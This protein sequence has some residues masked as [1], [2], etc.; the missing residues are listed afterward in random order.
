MDEQ[1]EKVSLTDKRIISR[2]LGYAK[3]QKKTFLVALAMMVI[4][5]GFDLLLPIL[6][7]L[8]A[9]IL[10][11]DVIDFNRIIYIVIAYAVCLAVMFVIQYYQGMSLQKAGQKIIYNVRE[12]VFSHIENYSTG[13]INSLPVGKMVTRITNDTNTLNEMYTSVIMNLLKD[14]LTVVGVI[15][16][17]LLVD[18]Q[19]SLYVLAV[20]PVLVFITFIFRK[21]SREAYRQVRK[22]IANINAFLSENISGMK[23]TQVFNQEE[24]KLREFREKNQTL[25]R[26]SLR[27]TFIFGVFRPMIYVLYV[28]TLILILWFGG[29]NVM[30]QI[31]LTFE[32]IIIFYQ[33]LDKLYTP[34]QQLAEQFNVLQSAF[35]AAE[36]IF[37]VLDKTPEIV[38]EEGA[39]P[40]TD[41]K[42][43]I[44][45]KNVWFSYIDG[46]WILKDVSFK[47]LPGETVAF[48]GATG[49]GKTTI[50]SL[51]VR[52]YEIQKGQILIDGLDIKK[53]KIASLRSGIGQMLQDVFLFSGTIASNIRM[54]EESIS[55]SDI[56][57]A[58]EYVNADKFISGLP[59]GYQEEVRER[60]NNFSSGQRQLLSFARTVVH[61]PKIM[62]LDEAT[63]NID[64]E[65]E[66]LIQDSLEKMMNIGTMLVVAHRLSTIQ[67]ANKIIVLQ[68]GTII[69]EGTHQELLKKR[70][71][72][73]KLY[74]LQYQSEK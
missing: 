54:R 40:L 38:D 13:Q 18:V 50:L 24:K 43:E 41:L 8:A 52:N 65:T 67:H 69:E 15:I 63:A 35:A 59:N 32:V 34:I 57:Q 42:G 4:S 39:V 23:I 44:E 16:A 21:Y 31:G 62:I 30:L 73:Y 72:Y 7:G 6:L 11:Q 26:S 12:Q 56:Q 47:I 55:D 10:G 46:E 48:V 58:C 28:L 36:K 53:I 25:K 17:M 66:V 61:K 68:K 60:G 33:Y 45:F 1:R 14:S 3:S 74:K 29:K 19:L 2:L 20:C 27:E 70:G 64:T 22:N 9:K 5:V 71:Q 51:I 37:E 49:S